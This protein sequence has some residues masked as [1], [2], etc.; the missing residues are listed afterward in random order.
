M[1]RSISNFVNGEL[2]PAMSG[3]T[4]DITNP[5]TGEVY[6]TSPLSG[7]EDVDRV[8]GGRNRLRNLA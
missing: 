7:A 3:A 8:P 2:V 4:L 5:A 1:A 6:L